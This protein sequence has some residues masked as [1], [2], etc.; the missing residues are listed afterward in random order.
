[1]EHIKAKYWSQRQYRDVEIE[2]DDI[3][4]IYEDDSLDL[5]DVNGVKRLLDRYVKIC[6]SDRLGSLEFCVYAKDEIAT[7]KHRIEIAIPKI[8]ALASKDDKDTIVRSVKRGA[9]ERGE[10]LHSL[11]ISLEEL[12]DKI[13]QRKF[14]EGV[15]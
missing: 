4:A 15:N 3:D 13:E 12:D 5:D 2:I 1:M 10:L 6:K 7:V 11:E 9:R 14:Y 8:R